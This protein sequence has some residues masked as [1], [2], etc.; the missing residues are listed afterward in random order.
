[1]R[2]FSLSPLQAFVLGFGVA[3]SLSGIVL[4]TA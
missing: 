4:L 3:F 1:M 2:G